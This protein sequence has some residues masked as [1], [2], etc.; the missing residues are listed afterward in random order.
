MVDNLFTEE[1]LENLDEDKKDEKVKT[2]I[3]S[4]D[5]RE[6]KEDVL[7]KVK[8][9]LSFVKD[10]FSCSNCGNVF[11]VEMG[12]RVEC[13]GCGWSFVNKDGDLVAVEIP[14]MEEEEEDG[15]LVE[16]E[17]EEG[18]EEEGEKDEGL[19]LEFVDFDEW[20]DDLSGKE[21]GGSK[22]KKVGEDKKKKGEEDP[23]KM[24][25]EDEED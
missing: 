19:T 25:W 24:P 21:S 22:A 17:I 14:S 5:K 4:S 7:S 10:W 11:E 2:G 20:M 3:S 15:E 8:K 1:D 6:I 9:G 12:K 18:G 23:G 13:S 16:E